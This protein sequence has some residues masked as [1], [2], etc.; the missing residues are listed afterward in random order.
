MGQ[1]VSGLKNGEES[2][3][4]AFGSRLEH[5]N[6]VAVDTTGARKTFTKAA[7]H[8]KINNTGANALLVSFEPGTPTNFWTIAAGTKDEFFG[9]IPSVFLKSGSGTTN[10][11]MTG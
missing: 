9:D 4:A 8:V 1:Q 11:E 5:I 3:K 2:V 6:V 10:F 7:G